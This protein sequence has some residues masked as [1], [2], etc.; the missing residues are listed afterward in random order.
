MTK[1]TQ[2]SEFTKSAVVHP[3]IRDL[4]WA[5][6]FLEGEG[7]FTGQVRNDRPGLIAAIQATQA[8]DGVDSLQRLQRMFG[9]GLRP[10]KQ[11]LERKPT[12]IWYCSGPRARGVA[13][14]L[15]ALVGVRRQ[16]QIRE[17]LGLPEVGDANC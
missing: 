6:G 15:Y 1:T 4:E 10:R 12:F 2:T 11:Q 9:G 5:A 13:M 8:I 16:M 7:S 17:L 3:T 14:T